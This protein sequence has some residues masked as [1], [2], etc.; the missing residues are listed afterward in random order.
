MNWELLIRHVNGESTTEEIAEVDAWLNEKAENKLILK[1]LQQKQKQLTQPVK[2]DAIHTEWVKMLDRVFESPKQVG[3]AKIKPLFRLLSIAATLL[4]A[5]CITWYAVNTNKKIAN[6]IVTV[7]TTLERRQVTLPDG[8]A[9]YLAPNSTLKVSGAFGQKTRELTLTG[10]AFFDV[11]HDGKKSFIIHTANNLKVN[12]LGT[13]FNVYSRKGVNEEV[14][15]AT[16]LVGLVYGKSTIFIK[17]G[18]QGNY[19]LATQQASKT[20][21]NIQDASSLQ[22]GTLYFHNSRAEE[23]ARKIERYYN[24]QVSVAQSA[25]KQAAFSGEMKDYGVTKLLDGLGYATGI[26]YRFT[27]KN[28]ILLY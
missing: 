22:N 9:V 5:C 12:V 16:G 10:E 25:K 23:I 14:K 17:A 28:S 6:E 13:S 21:V 15:V 11:K 24:V 4:L 1:Q 18:Q 26:R 8:S 19:T 20:R 27:N 2:E 7:K 3:E